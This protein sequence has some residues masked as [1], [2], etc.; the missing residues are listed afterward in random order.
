MGPMVVVV[1]TSGSIGAR[2]LE[3]WAGEV[4]AVV[5][6][7]RPERLYVV[8]ADAAVQRV[9]EYTADDLPLK[10]EPRG[11]GGT[12]FRPAFAWVDAQDIAPDCLLYLTDMLGTFPDQDP[13]YPVMWCSTRPGRVGPIGETIHV[14]VL[15]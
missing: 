1:D 13:G 3:A 11:G 2:T 8:Y 5:E 12:D 10:L 14:E 15:P 6:D 4:S 9:E 7:V